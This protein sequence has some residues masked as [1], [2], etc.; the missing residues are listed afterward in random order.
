[1]K[2]AKQCF[3]RGFAAIEIDHDEI[4]SPDIAAE[5]Y[6]AAISEF[7]FGWKIAPVVTLKSERGEKSLKRFENIRTDKPEEILD[8]RLFRGSGGLNFGLR[9]PL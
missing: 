6:V 1:M 9:N 2:D 5:D 7:V 4:A 3:S 8:R